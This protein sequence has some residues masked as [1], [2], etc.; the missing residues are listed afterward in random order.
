MLYC[1]IVDMV[2]V[3]TFCILKVYQQHYLLVCLAQMPA[4]SYFLKTSVA[5]FHA[6]TM[7]HHLF[8]LAQLS[9]GTAFHAILLM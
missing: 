7:A 8:L 4:V 9:F 1:L 5:F 6:L 2:V 3:V